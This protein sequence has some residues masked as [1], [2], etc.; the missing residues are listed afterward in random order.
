M[1]SWEGRST[2]LVTNTHGHH[3]F[4]ILG[5]VMLNLQSKAG[6]ARSVALV[7]APSHQ[8]I[9]WPFHATLKAKKR[10]SMAMMSPLA[11]GASETTWYNQT[12]F[13]VRLYPLTSLHS[14]RSLQPQA[15]SKA[16]PLPSCCL[17]LLWTSADLICHAI[18]IA[19]SKQPP[20]QK[21]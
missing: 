8:N 14:L 1:P 19:I 5:I 16:H 11:L 13:S 15:L 12:R 7:G 17:L 2:T 18:A 20:S 6:Q 10:Y 21:Q 4:F 3:L 9:D